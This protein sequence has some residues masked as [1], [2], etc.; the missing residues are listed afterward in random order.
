MFD[1]LT[2]VAAVVT[3]LAASGATWFATSSYYGEREAKA[4]T[5]VANYVTSV[6]SERLNSSMQIIALQTKIGEI[7]AEGSAKLKAAKDENDA[8]RDCLRTGK[9]GLFV[10]VRGSSTH[11]ATSTSAGPV[12]TGAGAGVGAGT[13]CRLDAEAERN[14]S[15]LT[16]GIKHQKVQIETL[17]DIVK[18]LQQRK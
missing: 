9:C 12:A 14:Y 17:I 7:D 5:D 18:Q 4:Q 3:G 2:L 1:R 8:M 16:D 13:A 6:T 10:T 15:D 11:A